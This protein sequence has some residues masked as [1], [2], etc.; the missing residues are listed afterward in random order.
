MN[1][2]R[3]NVFKIVVLSAF[4]SLKNNI[5]NYVFVQGTEYDVHLADLRIVE[6]SLITVKTSFWWK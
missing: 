6:R 1:Y 5:S 3:N 2:I 4:S